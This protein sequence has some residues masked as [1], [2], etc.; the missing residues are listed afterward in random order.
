[1]QGRYHLIVGNIGVVG[2]YVNIRNAVPDFNS[3]RR[4][5]I[6]GVG[7]A[8]GEPVVLFDTLSDDPVLEYYPEDSKGVEE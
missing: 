8:A 2:C 5:S 4:Q 3:Y 6:D 7:R 1:M